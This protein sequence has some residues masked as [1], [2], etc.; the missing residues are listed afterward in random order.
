M[1]LQQPKPKRSPIAIALSLAAHAVV[2]ALILYKPEPPLIQPRLVVVGDFGNAKVTYLSASKRSVNL[3][4]PPP[5]EKVALAKVTAPAPQRQDKSDVHNRGKID[6]AN[7]QMRAGGRWG[8]YN[9]DDFG[10]D[11]RPALPYQFPDPD[12]YPWQVPSG[13][14]GNVVVEVTIDEQGVVTATKLL[15]GLT[16]LIDGK[17]VATVRNWRF[18]PATEN[19]KAIASKQDVNFHYPV[20]RVG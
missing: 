16:E 10:P 6:L 3:P 15:Q 20:K 12:V 11:I 1:F 17:C 7:T 5:Q 9:A 13:V 19:G 4:P 18:H 2:I 8:S 14:E